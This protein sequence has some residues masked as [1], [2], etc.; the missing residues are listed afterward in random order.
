MN[1]ADYICNTA[2]NAADCIDAAMRRFERSKLAASG[3]AKVSNMLLSH[4]DRRPGSNARTHEALASRRCGASLHNPDAARSPT[5]GRLSG[6]AVYNPIVQTGKASRCQHL[7]QPIQ[8]LP[9]PWRRP[10][11][12][13]RLLRKTRMPPRPTSNN[14]RVGSSNST[15]PRAEA[16]ALRRRARTLPQ[17]ASRLL[18]RSPLH[19]LRLPALRQA[20][21]RRRARVILQARRRTQPARLAQATTSCREATCRRP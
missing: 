13:S 19:R 12:K 10:K 6:E 14:W 20:P 16:L 1:A 2:D 7:Y 11:R 15:P 17:P 4:S 8:T 21:P 9:A 18:V 5:T 3:Q